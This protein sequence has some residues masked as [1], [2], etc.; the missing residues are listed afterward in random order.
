MKNL[1]S[2]QCLAYTLIN[3]LGPV[4]EIIEQQH[5]DWEDWNL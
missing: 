4:L 5:D 3:K 2:A 1:N